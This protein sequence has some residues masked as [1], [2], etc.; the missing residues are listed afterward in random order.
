MRKPAF[1]I[2]AKT[3]AQIRCTYGNSVADQRL[4]FCYIDD[5][6]R[7]L[8]K[9]LTIFYGFTVLFVSDLVGKP[10]YRFSYDAFLFISVINKLNLSNQIFSY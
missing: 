3:K 10:E 2:Y 6:I 7:L 8:L 4:C 5:T 1:Y 9:P